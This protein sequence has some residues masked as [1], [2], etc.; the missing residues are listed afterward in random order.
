[1]SLINWGFAAPINPRPVRL[2]LIR[3][4]GGNGAEPTIVWRSN[5]SVADVQQWQP[6][7]PGDP[8][9]TPLEHTFTATVSAPTMYEAGLVCGSPCQLLLGL[10]LPDQRSAVLGSAPAYSMRFANDADDVTWLV[11]ADEGGVNVLGDIDVVVK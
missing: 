1:M 7:E 10:S 6:Y 11:V 3:L 5:E 2:V 4:H 8:T 9:F